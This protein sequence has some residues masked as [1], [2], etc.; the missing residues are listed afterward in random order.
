MI[1]LCV[2]GSG[3]GGAVVAKELAERGFRVVVLEEGPRVSRADFDGRTTTAFA[4]LY[5]DGGFTLARGA[6]HIP[7]PMGRVVGGTTV[8]NSGTCLRAP[9]GVLA[10]WGF[11]AVEMAALYEEVE[12]YLDVNVVPPH[13]HA[14]SV[15]LAARGLGALGLHG[16]PLPRNARDDRGCARCI[17]GCPTDAKRAM[18]VTYVPAAEAH[19]AVVLDGARAVRVRFERDRAVGVDA[20]RHGRRFRLRARAVVVAA[21]AVM[22]PVLLRASGVRHPDLGRHLAIHPA[23]R[24]A[25]LFE[26]E[27]APWR[28]VP[29]SFG[30]D[31]GDGLL[32]EAISAPPGIE[33]L[34][35]P[36]AGA[37]EAEA[38]AR[39]RNLATFG[40][41]V[42]DEGRGTVRRRG[43]RAIVSY[44]LHERD[45]A[46]ILRGIS[47]IS[48]AFLLAGASRVF[49]PVHGIEEVTTLEEAAR[50]E[51]E[52][53]PGT[54]LKLTAFHPTG[55]AAIGRV[56]DDRGRVVGRRA[57][58]IADASLL[59][60]P[61]GVNPQLTIMAL[62]TRIARDLAA[63]WGDD[64]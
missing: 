33:A 38:M 56:A 46:R 49:P 45:V 27:I 58:R 40:L 19:G 54:D 7:I 9:P 2:I 21:G 16:R 34:G 12:R 28:G 62:A 41:L 11:D 26:E 42:R 55:T 61:P 29:Q 63:T 15:A 3:A 47:L 31:A 13:L 64:A 8:V 4:R 48:R 44:R 5:R 59:P 17:L 36:F 51:T 39:Y 18:H 43:H 25:A 23:C 6:P 52:P 35:L 10:E 20:E 50:I 60:S 22:T 57:L 24:V 30:V 37:A 1:D 53:R 14:R 32:L